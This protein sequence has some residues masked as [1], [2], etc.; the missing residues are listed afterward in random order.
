MKLKTIALALAGA[1]L[2]CAAPA[3]AQQGPALVAMLLDSATVLMSNEDFEEADDAVVGTLGEGE[4]EEFEMEL[5]A[6]ESYIFVGVCDENCSDLDI[7]VYDEN[8]DEIDSDV[9]M[10]D[11]PM[12]AIEADEDMTVTIKVTMATCGRRCHYGLG[13]YTGQ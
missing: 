2:F 12:V 11:T 8:G 4:D 6:G 7:A 5:E 10:D 1:A 13:T 9:E 3:Q